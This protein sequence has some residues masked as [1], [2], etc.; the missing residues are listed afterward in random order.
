MLSGPEHQHLKET[1]LLDYWIIT[2]V[3]IDRNG[4]ETGFRNKIT[5]VV[6]D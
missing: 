4:F 2:T 3:L 6:V 5:F 1:S